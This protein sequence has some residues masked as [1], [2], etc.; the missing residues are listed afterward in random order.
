MRAH[1]YSSAGM[2]IHP[3]ESLIIA[4]WDVLSPGVVRLALC[5]L[6][7]QSAGDGWDGILFVYTAFVTSGHASQP[8]LRSVYHRPL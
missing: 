3:F 2:L 7:R 8:L 1:L 4:V 6:S 5:P